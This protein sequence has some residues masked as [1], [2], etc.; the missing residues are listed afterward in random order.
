VQA[1][2]DLPGFCSVSMLVNPADGRAATA[3]TYDS[4][5]AL[6]QSLDRATDLR[7]EFTRSMGA[8]VIEVASYELVVAQLRVPE[9]V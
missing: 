6:Q 7:Q 2:E 9:T 8:R 4:R 3:V 1:V 5:E